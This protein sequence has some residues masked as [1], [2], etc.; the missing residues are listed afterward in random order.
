MYP[1]YSE[2]LQAIKIDSHSYV[3]NNEQ[4]SDFFPELPLFTIIDKDYKAECDY[5]RIAETIKE[6]CNKKKA[7]V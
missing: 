4:I 6:F 2:L 7:S 5:K 3:E 1:V